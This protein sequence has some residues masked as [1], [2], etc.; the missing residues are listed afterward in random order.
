MLTSRFGIGVLVTGL[1][2]C[3]VCFAEQQDY[4]N[5]P[6]NMIVTLPAGSTVD[7]LA[8]TFGVQLT[9][10]LK[11]PVVI[12][13]KTGAGLVLGMQAVA[14]APAD[15]HT[16]AFTPVTPL[17]IQLNR[18]K[19]LSYTMN[20]FVPLCQTFENVFFLAVPNSSGIKDFNA[21][22]NQAKAQPGK[23]NYGHSGVGS[24]PHLM[25]AEL[26]QDLGVVVG[27]IPYRGETAFAPALLSGD[28]QS[29]LVT[30]ALIKQNSLRPLL[31]F[32][33][34]RSRAYPDVPTTAEVG[35]QVLA[36]AYGG[37]FVRADTP[38]AAISKLEVACREAVESSAYQTAAEAQ[39]QNATYLDRA[40]FTKRLN[41]DAR[42]KAKLL[43][44][45]KLP[46]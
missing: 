13:N 28:V 3:A 14:A 41:D 36:S 19:K 22:L 17:T 11:Q 2:S 8:R 45:V 34:Q 43:Q 4:P 32:A 5:K 37:L 9:A 15:G 16:L 25:A 12:D 44:T 20:S 40:T 23:L 29:G 33:A 31:V 38:P 6:L 21:F 35:A 26:W 39:S 18:G 42:S 46:E 27:D 10:R 7:A 30:T 1:L 24:S